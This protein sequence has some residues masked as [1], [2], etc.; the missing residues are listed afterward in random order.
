M[1][2][3]GWM[4][5]VRSCSI[6]LLSR[7]TC[8]RNFQV[9]DRTRKRRSS[10]IGVFSGWISEKVFDAILT[11]LRFTF[12]R[13]QRR[14]DGGTNTK[15]YCVIQVYHRHGRRNHC[16]YY[17]YYHQCWANPHNLRPSHRDRRAQPNQFN[18]KLSPAG[19]CW[20]RVPPPASHAMTRRFPAKFIF[21]AL[22][23]KRGA[24]VF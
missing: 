13:E 11:A 21:N 5:R 19:N 15:V 10:Y 3:R 2:A 14:V 18:V 8:V 24:K 6:V 9:S 16:Y 4:R 20:E 22:L 7:G 17:Y 23:D 12:H 1:E